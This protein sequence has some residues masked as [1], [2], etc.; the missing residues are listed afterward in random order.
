MSVLKGLGCFFKISIQRSC[1]SAFRGVQG[2]AQR[3]QEWENSGTGSVNQVTRMV[4]RERTAVVPHWAQQHPNVPLQKE[5]NQ[6]QKARVKAQGHG[7]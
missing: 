7:G 5:G 1:C 4:R 6:V 2:K 3:A